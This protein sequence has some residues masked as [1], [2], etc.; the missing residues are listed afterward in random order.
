MIVLEAASPLLVTPKP[1][2]PGRPCT[3]SPSGVYVTTSVAL[4]VSVGEGDGDVVSVGDGDVV[5]VGDGEV[6]SVG[7]GE[8]V[9]VPLPLGVGD[10]VSELDG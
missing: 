7:V 4:G 6:V 8:L 5:S 2:M 3:R 10:G 9:G 1:T